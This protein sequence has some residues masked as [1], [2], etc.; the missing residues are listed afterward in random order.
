MEL[1]G[2]KINFLGDSITQGVG[3]SC[4]QAR[5]PDLIAEKYGAVCRNYGI[6]GTCFAHKYG[7]NP[8][9]PEFAVRYLDMDADADIIVIFGGTNDYGHGQAPKG[10]PDD[11]TADTFYGACN[12]LF[13][14]V[15]QKYP[16]ATIVIMTPM[17]RCNE[18]APSGGSKPEDAMPLKDYVNI[19]RERAEFYSLPVLDLF[20]SSGIQ[21]ELP[22]MREKYMPDGLHPNDAGHKILA[23]KLG[24]F[25]ENM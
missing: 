18:T 4:A 17:H 10:N 15:T 9:G 14:G 22:I 1:K 16:E 11:T 19:I 3:V 8:F 7:E 6:S 2:K 13:S 20:A 21:P 25:L 5:F 23:D 12:V 24:K